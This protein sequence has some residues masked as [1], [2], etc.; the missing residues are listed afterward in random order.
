MKKLHLYRDHEAFYQIGLIA[1]WEAHCR[2][3]PKKGGFS[4]FAYSTIR[5]RLLE[6]LTK[7]NQF[8]DRFCQGLPSEEGFH[9]EDPNPNLPFESDTMEHYCTG[10]SDNQRKWVQKRIIEDKRIIDIAK[11]EEVTTDAVKSWGRAAI[12]KM[13]MN[14]LN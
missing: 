1:L 12:K 11:E 4:T 7:E 6:Y 5:G 3:D 2:F 9:L 8:Y 14:I 13:R 10:L